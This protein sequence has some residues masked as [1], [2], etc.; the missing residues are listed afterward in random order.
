MGI[1][2]GIGL[3]AWAVLAPRM[4]WPAPSLV[5][6]DVGSISLLALSWANILPADARATRERAGSEDP[7]RTLV[8]VV[9][10][11]ASAVSL[12]SATMLVR[13][14]RQL[15]PDIARA[16]AGLCLC[17][18]ALAWALTHTAYTFRYA[19]LYYREDSEGVGGVE[20]P[21]EHPPTYFDFAY[22]AFTIGMCFQ[23]SDVCV[24]SRQIRRTVLF[25][26]LVSFAYNSVILAFVLQLVFGV[27]G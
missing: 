9:V 12:L 18:V 14:A 17:T 21:G 20:L 19:R 25:H 16:I 4:P 1:S 24:T 7:G 15:A 2:A 22:F 5:G 26:A 13:E 3:V 23:V 8:Y 6:W 10:V 27:A 11:L